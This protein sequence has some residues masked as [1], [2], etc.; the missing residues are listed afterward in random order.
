MKWQRRQTAS[1]NSK[2]QSLLR[3]TLPLLV[4]LSGCARTPSVDVFGS[5]FP[6]W[7]FCLA[8]GILLTLVARRLL[9]V[10]AIDKDLGPPALIYPCLAALLAC[11]IW[12]V[13]FHD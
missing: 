9:V 2:S 8:G 1:M 12:M 11:A 13:G 5:F 7:M 10:A 4:G 3:L 6:V